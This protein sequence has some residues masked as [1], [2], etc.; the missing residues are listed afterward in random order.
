MLSTLRINQGE[1]F[2]KENTNH[3]D[4]D[5][6]ARWGRLL[7]KRFVMEMHILKGAPFDCCGSGGKLLRLELPTKF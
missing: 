7:S 5:E 1:S 2:W 4:D 3:P 6:E